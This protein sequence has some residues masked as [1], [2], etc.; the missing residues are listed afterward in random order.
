[1][2]GF[3]YY[4]LFMNTLSFSAFGIDK[5]LAKKQSRR[6]SE[7]TLHLTSL[8]GGTPGSIMGMILFKH[9]TKKKKFICIT[10]TILILQLSAVKYLNKSKKSLN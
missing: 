3:Y 7:R 10:M 5:N 8:C 6:I 1:M 2:D 4:F 9:K